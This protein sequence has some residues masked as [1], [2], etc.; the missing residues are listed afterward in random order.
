MR[1]SCVT[2]ESE[3]TQQTPSHINSHVA[4]VE[5]L[6]ESQGHE[7]AQDT[8][9]RENIMTGKNYTYYIIIL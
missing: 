1:V 7:L 4:L 3:V 2:A 6:G 5:M 9:I 8:R